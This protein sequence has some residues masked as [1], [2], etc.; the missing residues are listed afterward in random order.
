MGVPALAVVLVAVGCGSHALPAG[1]G[2]GDATADLPADMTSDGRDAISD[3]RDAPADTVVCCPIGAP[4]CSCFGYGGARV[5]GMCPMICDAG[6]ANW[7]MSTDASGCPTLVLSGPYGDCLRP[8]E[9][10]RDGSPD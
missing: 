10:R 2:Q 4:G 9:P 5:N 6:G 8:P 1:G 7:T 3:V